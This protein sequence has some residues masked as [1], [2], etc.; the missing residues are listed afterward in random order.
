[1]RAP[2]A[3]VRVIA[4]GLLALGGLQAVSAAPVIVGSKVFTES[5]I[6][7]EVATQS[8]RQQGIEARHDRELGST[9]ILWTALLSGRI[10]TYVEYT[11]TIAAELLNNPELRTDDELRAALA[12]RG[13]RMS[14]PLGFIDTYAL[15]VRDDL[16]QRLG[17]ASISD[18]AAHPEL[19]IGLSNEFLGR[20]DGWPGLSATYHLQAFAPKGLDHEVAYRGLASG[21]I[22]V[23]DF[24][25]TDPEID[26]NHLRILTDDRRFFPDYR[27]VYLYRTNARPEMVR[28]LDSLGGR[29]DTAGMRRL[30]AAVTLGHRAEAQVAA[31]WL[32]LARETVGQGES[33]LT[34]ILTRLREHLLLSGLSALVAVLIGIPLGI[35]S[36]RRQGVGRWIIGTSGVLQTVPSLA[37]LVFMIPVLGLGFLP[38]CVALFLYSLLPIVRGT[39][40]G[41]M[42]IPASLQEAATS[43]GLTTRTRLTRIELPLAM[44]SILSG[45]KTASVINVGTATLGAIIGAGGFG[46]TIMSGI[47]LNDTGLI[48]EGAI[49]AALLAVAVEFG[50]EWVESLIRVPATSGT[51]R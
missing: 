5:V 40:T 1:M 37:L 10:D 48:L 3:Y 22:D 30:N 39:A 41:L 14:A 28:V 34:R 35:V 8:L 46:Q 47:R 23:T 17:L 20:A 13:L 50:F 51:T 43:L 12:A 4:A 36:A 25:S 11:G 42:E 21:S 15:G 31:E 19:R 29:L 7:G 38:A 9:R 49:P 45:I 33:R 6:L 18:L 27:G 16:A 32:G 26:R 24:Y 44:R 2:V